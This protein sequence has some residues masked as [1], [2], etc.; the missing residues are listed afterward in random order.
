MSMQPVTGLN[1]NLPPLVQQIVQAKQSE[2]FA[3]EQHFDFWG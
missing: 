3:K 2:N 1:Q